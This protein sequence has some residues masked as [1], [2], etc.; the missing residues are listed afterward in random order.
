VVAVGLLAAAVAVAWGSEVKTSVGRLP[1]AA[2]AA[3]PS[4]SLILAAGAAAAAFFVGLAALHAAAAM[5]VLAR[6]RRIR[7]R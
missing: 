7:T 2:A 6:D 1:V 3:I 4:V 5:R